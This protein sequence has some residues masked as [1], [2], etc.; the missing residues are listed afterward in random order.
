[1]RRLILINIAEW[2]TKKSRWVTRTRTR[3]RG[4]FPSWASFTLLPLLPLNY[5][6]PFLCR[7]SVPLAWPF[8]SSASPVS[9]QWLQDSQQPQHPQLQLWD[10]ILY[11]L[12]VAVHFPWPNSLTHNPLILIF[13]NIGQEN[14]T[15]DICPTLIGVYFWG[16]LTVWTPGMRCRPASIISQ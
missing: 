16:K 15:C 4:S 9:S 14:Y 8:F 7:M 12:R 13:R 6:G 2:Q 11:N 1:M 5:F 10:L 3:T